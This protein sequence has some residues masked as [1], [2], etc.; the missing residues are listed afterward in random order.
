[1]R[2]ELEAALSTVIGTPA[3]PLADVDVVVRGILHASGLPRSF[4]ITN[5][6]TKEDGSGL[7]RDRMGAAAYEKFVEDA[8]NDLD[9]SLLYGPTD[10]ELPAIRGNGYAPEKVF[11]VA[12]QRAQQERDLV[13][14]LDEDLETDWRHGRIR[15]VVASRELGVEMIDQFT[16][17]L[18]ARGYEIGQFPISEREE[19]RRFTRSMP[20][21][22]VA[23]EVKTR[24]HRERGHRWT[25][26]DIFDIDAMSVAVPY[27]DIVFTDG[28]VQNALT[29][30]RIDDRM[31]TQLPRKIRD[32]VTILD[33]L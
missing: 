28:A 25:P 33:T 12:E 31:S 5:T 8:L 11:V 7:L 17:M 24:Y 19:I 4:T 30:A 16:R 22:E 13:E 23:I 14:N 26:N 6:E 20:G 29:T 32:L 1:M 15:D 21:A 9:H 27:C 2:H 3:E 18:M 10:D